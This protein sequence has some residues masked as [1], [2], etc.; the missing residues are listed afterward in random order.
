MLLH[1]AHAGF[2]LD[3]NVRKTL[4]NSA[5]PNQDRDSS[6]SG[7]IFADLLR[8]KSLED[9]V[10]QEHLFSKGSALRNLLEAGTFDSLIFV[11]PPGTGK[12]TAAM[13]ACDIQSIPFYAL[14]ATTAGTAELKQISDLAA[15]SG[16]P[17]LVFID[18]IHR[19]N[20][21]Q[22]NLLLKLVDDRRIKIIGASTENPTF[23]LVPAFRSRSMIFTFRTLE[24]D[25]M[26]ALAL[27]AEPLIKERFDVQ[28]IDSSEVIDDLIAEA[29]G[30][31]RRFLNML[32]ITALLGK[33]DSD[34]LT[35]S[36]EGLEDIVRKRRYDTDEYYDLLSA[37]I[38][39][40][41]GSDPDAAI[42]WGFKMIKSGVMPEV[43]F[44]RLIISASE[45]IGNAY[46]DALVFINNAYSAF[47][48]VGIPEGYII[49]AHALTYLATCPKSNRSYIAF[50]K[51]Q[52]FLKEHDPIVPENIANNHVGY[53]Y[54]HDYNGFVHQRYMPDDIRFY[55]PSE[56]GHELKISERLSRLWGTGAKKYDK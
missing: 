12:T 26:R 25:D 20:K 19:Y 18:E 33:R 49:L 9:I 42:L 54:P 32:E 52:D 6:N 55:E 22:Q 8:P 30:D 29:A 5:L 44:R 28:Q 13:I 45:D 39:S 53:L 47:M 37:M 7:M 34:K 38:K 41:R 3:K 50:H 11:G 16:S 46:P 43:I 24:A 4:S 35:L 27:K 2:F 36:S 21:T 10:G 23:T 51:V 31:A 1:T 14:H 17:V 48:N 56:N 40:I 15:S